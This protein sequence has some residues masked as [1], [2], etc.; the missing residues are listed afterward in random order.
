MDKPH[1]PSSVPI[2]RVILSEGDPLEARIFTTLFRYDGS[3]D[4]RREEEWVHVIEDK[5]GR[6]FPN[7]PTSSEWET[8]YEGA[9][10]RCRR[11]PKDTRSSTWELRVRRD[12][13]P[14]YVHMLSI[15]EYYCDDATWDDGINERRKYVYAVRVD[16][17][18][19]SGDAH[20]N[21]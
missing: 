6:C 15:N 3:N 20:L 11:D 14:V 10:L 9:V 1:T 21:V 16:V 8:T 12:V 2:D 5:E 19:L 7:V 4:H 18:A 17:G 13:A